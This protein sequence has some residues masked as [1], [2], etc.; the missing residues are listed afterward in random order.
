MS[1]QIVDSKVHKRQQQ[2][3]D[4]THPFRALNDG[5]MP[6]HALFEL[7][8]PPGLS[9]AEQGCHLRFQNRKIGEDLSF[10]IGHSG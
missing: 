1:P 6:F 8:Q 3:A 4:G 2:P 10:K 9:V 7:M 5:F